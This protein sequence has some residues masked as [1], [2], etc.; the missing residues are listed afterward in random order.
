MKTGSNVIT[1]YWD[2]GKQPER[3][4]DVFCWQLF[5]CGIIVAHDCWTIENSSGEVRGAFY[6]VTGPKRLVD[7]LSWLTNLAMG[8]T[9][10]VNVE[11]DETG[12]ISRV[13]EL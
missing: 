7:F 6:H 8:K 2:E 3:L 10:K 4:R 13:Q 1:V 12:Q 9:H 11:T 5:K